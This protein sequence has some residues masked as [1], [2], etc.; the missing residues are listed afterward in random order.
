MHFRMLTGQE[1]EITTHS[2]GAYIIYLGSHPLSWSSKK[3][4]TVVQSFTEMEYC[5]VADTASKLCWVASVLC[6]LGIKSTTQPAI[7]CDNVGAMYLCVNPV[8][9]SRMK[10]VILDY[11]F[12]CELVQSA[13]LHVSHVSSKD[14]LADALTKLVSCSLPEANSSKIGLFSGHSSCGG[15]SR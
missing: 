15:I 3:Q 12:I 14:Q 7:Y 2:R 13:A 9:Q 8:F 11:H 6:E 5:A 10:H 1:I 4:K